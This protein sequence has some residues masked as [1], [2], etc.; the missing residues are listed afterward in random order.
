[1][2]IAIP[3]IAADYRLSPSESG[4]LMSVFFAGYSITQVPGGILADIFGARRIATIAM[5]WW[6]ALT[7][8]TGAAAN[9]IQMAIVRF[10]FG[11]GE[12]MF[13]A[14]SFKSIAVWFPKKERATANAIMLASN[15]VGAAIA[16]LAVVAIMS[17]WGWRVVFYSLSLPG[18]LMALLFWKFIPDKPS[19]SRLVSPKELAEIEQN[20]AVDGQNSESKLGLFAILRKPDV[21]KYFF[22]LLTFNIAFWGFTAW[23]PTYLVKA[24]G[25]S[26]AQM[27]AAAALP[28][29]VGATGVILG[30]GISDRFFSR[31]RRRPIIITQLMS[32]F[33]LYL[34]Y[35]ATSATALV[36]SETL[37]G[38][39]LNVFYSAFWAL[40]MNTVPKEL[41][42]V[43]GGFI[44]MAGQ[45][46]AFISP[47][48]VGY[49]V[50][51]SG[52]DFDRAFIFLISALLMSCVFAFLLPSNAQGKED[53][54]SIARC[55][56]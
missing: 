43:I 3:Y 52:G 38:L 53:R 45:I 9:V 56:D 30:G 51:A 35:T 48:V 37:A 14:C 1:M 23:L 46:A 27:G 33:L 20:S 16:P 18:V 28:F 47:L 15:P 54:A 32:A 22:I 13:P 6:S 17:L 40:P 50:G 8:I 24:R 41:M 12:G 44:N 7:A 25:F 29:V 34:T 11:F 39:F 21:L 36:I 2:S 31:H 26:M 19:D 49:L 10:V 42:G 55:V 4:L 5:L